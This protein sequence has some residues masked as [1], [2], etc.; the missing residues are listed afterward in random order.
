MDRFITYELSLWS[1]LIS[2]SLPLLYFINLQFNSQSQGRLRSVNLGLG[3]ASII[4]LFYSGF[5]LLS[6]DVGGAPLL[7]LLHILPSITTLLVLSHAKRL[8]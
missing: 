4:I 2:A 7:E 5:V 6:R 3:S 1:A 8:G